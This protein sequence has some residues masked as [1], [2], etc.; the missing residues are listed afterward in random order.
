MTK[1]D[2][3]WEKLFKCHSILESIE[4]YG[5]HEI[6]S[7]QINQER[8]SRLMA[9]FDHQ[10]SLP[11]IFQQHQLAILPISRSSYIIARIQCYK[12]LDY[13]TEK[14]EFVSVPLLETLDHTNLYSESAALSFAFNA[15]M[16]DDIA[17]EPVHFTI[18]GR[19]STGEFDYDISQPDT[20][21]K[22]R[23]SVKNSQCE[24]DGGFEGNNSILLIEVK[25][26]SS[27]DFIIRQLYYPY[28]LW[29]SK[30][31][32]PII[33]ILL[34]YSND[35]FNFFIYE[36]KDIQDYN[37]ISLKQ[38][39]KYIIEP[40]PILRSDIDQIII[41]SPAQSLIQTARNDIPF[42]QADSFE[43]VIDLLNL[44]D[45]RDLEKDEITTRYD[46]TERQTDYYTRATMYLD[47]VEIGEENGNT[48]FRLSSIGK[49]LVK[50]KSREKTL[51]LIRI[52]LA[53]SIF[54]YTFRKT[55]E[56]G[57]IPDTETTASIIE[58]ATGLSGETAKRRSRTLK[59][60]I[61]WILDQIED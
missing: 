25:N 41:E 22:L 5:C 3:A 37:S 10:S 16:L 32:K 6:T 14:P 40:E 57:R 24:V 53:D 27:R 17:G 36:F 47:L 15:G 46:F 1:T 56:L 58:S 34:I 42:P 13:T 12:Q 30:V 35:V 20:D 59:S 43:R 29:Q 31:S 45:I 23:V 55:L 52:L 18:S 21:K 38:V 28:R 48:V 8:E 51:E 60:W 39:S 4:K 50:R 9:K 11:R 61:N 19:M 33:P 7:T 54:F 2:E 26:H 44:L 49:N